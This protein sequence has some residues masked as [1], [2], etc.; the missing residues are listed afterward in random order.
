MS[1]TISLFP[2]ERAARVVVAE[3]DLGRRDIIASLMIKDGY[4]VRELSSAA[5]LFRLI[6]AFEPDLLIIGDGLDGMHAAE[7]CGELR[8][9]EAG[10][11]TPVMIIGSEGAEEEAVVSGLLAGAD[12]YVTTT[13]RP[14]ELSARARVQ[15]RNRR[16]LEAIRRIRAERDSFR[17]DATLDALTG[18]LN[19]RSLEQELRQRFQSGGTMA[20]LFFDLDHFKQVNDR[21]GHDV[22]D[23][24]LRTTARYIKRQMRAN[25]ICGR[26]GGEE[27]I[28]VLCGLDL[29]TAGVVAERHRRAVEAIPFSRA[30]FPS[31][32]TASIGVAELD[33]DRPDPSVEKL[34]QRADKALY[35]AKKRGRNRVVVAPPFDPADVSEPPPR[36][37]SALSA[38]PPEES[39]RTVNEPRSELEAYLVTQ[40]SGRVAVPV[41]PDVAAD[42][43]L[44]ANDPNSEVAQLAKLIAKSPPICARFLAIANSAL[45]SRGTRISSPEIAV[46]RL[47]LSGARDLLFQ[48]A[49]EAQVSGLPRYAPEVAKSFQRSVMAGHAAR[50]AAS[51]LSERHDYAY[52]YG[53]LHDIGEAHVYRILAASPEVGA[54][55]LV[56]GLV[57]QYHSRAGAEI[58]TAWHL[59]AEIVEVCAGHHDD[60]RAA[61]G[62]VRLVMIADAVVDAQ[63]NATAPEPRERLVKLGVS[64]EAVAQILK[65][66][67]DTSEKIAGRE[68][69]R[70]RDRARRNVLPHR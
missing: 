41:L 47:G 1:A 31:R 42:A 9:R 2:T 63:Q 40:L 17:R 37:A 27:F 70:D 66:L 3:G 20:V 38:E 28:I 12:D 36:A 13:R 29:H 15:L 34:L 54:K 49:Y 26:Y 45:Y 53:L 18:V 4:E 56:T 62:P 61:V 24:V 57:A 32:I 69:D 55:E 33:P 50:I 44:L 7:I 65:T 10:K 59:P 51:T 52:L 43:M 46:M 35:E 6:E 25:D 58:A 39:V 64:D 23:E 19:R 67:A 30:K 22:G 48:V 68:R 21:Y 11:H 16:V 8:A 60:E 14:H 5:D